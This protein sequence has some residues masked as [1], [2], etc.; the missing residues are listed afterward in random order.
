VFDPARREDLD[1]PI[2]TRDDLVPGAAI[3]GPALIVEDQTT[4][5]VT[6]TFDVAVN[7]LGYLMLTSKRAA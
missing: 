5:V 2:Y 4:T 7:P 3:T 1:Y 6:S